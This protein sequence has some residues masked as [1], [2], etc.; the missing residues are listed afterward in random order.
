MNV[1][2]KQILEEIYKSKDLKECLAKIRPVHIQQDILQYTFTELLMKD[3][4][5]IIEL[6]A[7]NKLM[8]YI[9]K[10][11]Y[12]MV[13]WERGT[14]RKSLLKEMIVEVLPDIADEQPTEII[15]IPLEKIYWYDAKILELYAELGT[16]RKV[17]E[18][19]GIPHITI[20]HTVNKAR[21]NIKKHIDL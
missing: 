14:Y 8:S 19:T 3:E 16:Y 1:D 11:L 18:V 20:Y 9:A 6:Y 12:N 17:A 13:R 21:K 7:K 4:K 10:M 5:I 15:V 2:S